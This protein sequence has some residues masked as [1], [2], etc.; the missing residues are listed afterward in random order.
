MPAT[1][2]V[3]R[4]IAGD[5]RSAATGDLLRPAIDDPPTI[6]DVNMQL[7]HHNL[8]IFWKVNEEELVCVNIIIT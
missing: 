8:P 2:D 7:H 1:G 5:G 4:A 6:I 3:Q